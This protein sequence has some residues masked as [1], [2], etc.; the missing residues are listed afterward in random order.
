MGC[1]ASKE[2]IERY[3]SLL[4]ERDH[5][6]LEKADLVRRIELL[7]LNRSE[8]ES[9]S[10]EQ[11][12]MYR[13]K[14]EVLVQMLAIEEK[15]QQTVVKRLETLKLALLN[16]GVS[17]KTMTNILSQT[18]D[19]N[20]SKD[21]KSILLTSAFD[22]S[23]AMGRMTEEM[24][25]S[26]EDIIYSFADV[27]GKIV[28]ALPREDFMR[29][30]YNATSTL[31]KAD[32][33]ILSLRFYDGETVCVPEFIDF[34]TQSP[35]SR[36]AR[37]AAAAVRASLN[38]LQLQESLDEEAPIL[39]GTARKKN[40]VITCC[41][42]SHTR[43]CNN[44]PQTSDGPQTRLHL[45]VQRLV[46]L[47]SIV[48]ESL[49]TEF[50]DIEQNVGGGHVVSVET[51]KVCRLSLVDC[52]SNYHQEVLTHIAGEQRSKE[53]S[54][55]KKSGWDVLRSESP[56]IQWLR[57]D[58]INLIA[59]RFE[60][61]NRIDVKVFFD[62]FQDSDEKLATGSLACEPFKFS[63]EWSTLRRS[64]KRDLVTSGR[65]PFSA[66]PNFLTQSLPI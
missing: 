31:T 41:L 13:F 60:L 45:A 17:N 43:T 57:E 30:L 28:S 6:A 65:Q 22:L 10:N 24:V 42:I 55:S 63:E 18:N 12:N 50:N 34:F 8:F 49:R 9:Q 40:E 51:F 19:S 1:G 26:A 7:E 29:Y 2:D 47:W 32:V 33:Q 46:S 35:N 54:T 23:G 25:S 44:S 20:S 15:K 56:K 39:A 16:Q 11:L 59:S 64:A 37:S 61:G 52:S 3:N 21:E 58:D 48:G 5:L 36:V 66:H 62:F 38:F 4:A 14:I 53:K 27:E